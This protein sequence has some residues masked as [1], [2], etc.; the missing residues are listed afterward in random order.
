MKFDSQWNP[1]IP[2]IYCEEN[3]TRHMTPRIRSPSIAEILDVNQINSNL[4]ILEDAIDCPF[5]N[6][7]VV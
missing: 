4:I 1:I 6:G 5:Y 3:S 7:G 2:Q